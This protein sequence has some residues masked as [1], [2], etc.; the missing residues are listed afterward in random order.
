MYVHHMLDAIETIANYTRGV[1]QAKFYKTKLIQDGVIRNLL[2]LGEAAKR[3]P[4]DI[5]SKHPGIDWRNIAG[6]RDVL[7][8]DYLGVD[9]EVLW[10]VIENHLPELR[11]Q[12][13]K[14]LDI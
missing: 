5:R 4:K 6:M 10:E 1:T 13:E 8:H 3:V 2:I 7:V 11:Q 12:L 14:I 9:L